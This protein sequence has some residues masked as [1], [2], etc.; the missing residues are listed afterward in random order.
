MSLIA[1]NYHNV[2]TLYFMFLYTQGISDESDDI[3][4]QPPTPKRKVCKTRSSQSPSQ[5]QSTL[6][7]DES[8]IEEGKAVRQRF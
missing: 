6:T 3:D 7:L 8:E 1:L 5:S 2:V 4:F